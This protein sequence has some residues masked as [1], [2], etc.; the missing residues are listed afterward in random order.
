VTERTD[1]EQE[2]KLSVKYGQQ[3]KHKKGHDKIYL[4]AEERFINSKLNITG[5]EV[6]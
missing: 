4:S 1:Q 3:G 5:F 2:I 6:M